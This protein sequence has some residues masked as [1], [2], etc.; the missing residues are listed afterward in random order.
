MSKIAEEAGLLKIYEIFYTFLSMFSHGTAT[1]ILAG[2]AAGPEIRQEEMIT[3]HVE[4]A[5]S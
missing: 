2:V 1:E 5:R 4:A 3:V